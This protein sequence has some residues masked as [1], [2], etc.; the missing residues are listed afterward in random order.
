MKRPAAALASRAGGFSLI[1]LMIGMTLGLI[2]LSA[3]IGVLLNISS[4]NKDLHRS[5]RQLDNARF[6]MK[7]LSEDIMH[8]GFYGQYDQASGTLPIADA[9]PCLTTLA[10]LT[11]DL[12]LAV[13]GLDAQDT[14][15]ARPSCIPSTQYLLGTDILVL[16]RG[17]TTDESAALDADKVYLQ[18]RYDSIVVNTGADATV[19][20]LQ[21]TVPT[22]AETLPIRR[23]ELHIY[24]VSPCSQTGSTCNDGIPSLKRLELDGDGT[25]PAL[26]L[27]TVAL[28]IEDLQLYYAVDSAPAGN[29]DGSPDAI[30]GQLYVANPGDWS[31]SAGQ[32]AWSNVVAVEA[33]LLAR[34]LEI[35]AGYRDSKS[36][37]MSPVGAT[38]AFTVSGNGDAYKRRL[39][40][41]EMRLYNIVMRRS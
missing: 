23:Y 3:V 9:D 16:R 11:A 36:Y 14:D 8:A 40:A 19:F 39:L 29:L 35:T 32:T 10:A 24:F 15:F 5:S 17:G 26:T 28:G 27:H 41:Q 2:L 38:T 37:V 20:N 6:A 18:G 4:A 30:D 7:T 13:Q 25:N 12:A 22:P 33:F 34:N 21:N 1:E 31:T